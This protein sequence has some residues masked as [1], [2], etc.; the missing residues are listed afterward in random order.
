MQIQI[1]KKKLETAGVI[2]T[3]GLSDIELKGIEDKYHFCFPPDLREFLSFSLPISNGFP[4][5]RDAA[6]K[7][8][9][10]R[11]KW[12]YDGLCFDITNNTFWLEEWGERP[13]SSENACKIIRRLVDL[14]PVLI[15][16]FSHRYIPDK[17]CEGGNPVISVYQTD[18]I[19]YGC[20]LFDYL[21]NEFF[22]TLEERKCAIETS[23]RT[24]NRIEFWSDIIER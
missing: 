24:F 19:Y 8:I 9:T 11:L 2:F 10:E 3:S 13:R 4:N 6:E 20:N 14:A 5:W 22:R 12:P 23:H 1:I 21:E 15:P 18:I 16:I 17:P 7:E